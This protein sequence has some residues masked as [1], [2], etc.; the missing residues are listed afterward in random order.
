[1]A[2]H[3]IDGPGVLHTGNEPGHQI[4]GSFNQR[5][6]SVGRRLIVSRPSEV[7]AG[8][9]GEWRVVTSSTRWPHRTSSDTSNFAWHQ[10]PSLGRIVLDE[11]ADKE[12]RSGAAVAPCASGRDRVALPVLSAPSP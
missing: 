2:V 4:S 5:G 8:N 11:Y 3:K 12:G 9:S 7:R 10:P 6:A 1:M